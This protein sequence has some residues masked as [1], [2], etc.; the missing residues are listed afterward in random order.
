MS[1]DDERLPLAL[2]LPELEKLNKA[3]ADFIL[4]AGQA[5]NF[6]AE[7]YSIKNPL[8]LEY[9]PFVSKDVD[10]FG[11]IEGLY[12]IPGILDGELKRF[13]DLRQPVVGVFKTNSEPQLM[14]ELLRSIYGPVSAEKIA[15]RV[16][17]RNPIAVID[18][19]SLLV[20]K[21]HNAA[22]LEQE[23]RQDVRHVQMMV[24]ATHAYY[25]DLCQAVGDQITPRQFINECKY[26]L[27]Y[28]DYSSFKKG[29]SMA[30]AELTDCLP[31]KLIQE[32]GEQHESIG[33]FYQH[34]TVI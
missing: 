6:W 14:F 26:L 9:A 32:I 20:S 34:F 13:S 19:V 16:Q 28:A 27:S 31:L 7:F 1:S 11:P 3:G 15:A 23:D 22:G 18:P 21:A 5:V 24:L 4:V 25:A 10:L 2:Y 33:R 12:K 8:L 17:I 30:D 29:I